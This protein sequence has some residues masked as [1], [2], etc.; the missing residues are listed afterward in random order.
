MSGRTFSRWLPLQ[1]GLRPDHTALDLDDG[2]VSYAELRRLVRGLVDVWAS[3]SVGPLDRG[4]RV[5]LYLD[6]RLEA[7]V[8]VLA[9]LDLGAVYVP[10]PVETPPAR[11]RRILGSCGTRHLVTTASLA[12]ALRAE[13]MPAAI[14]QVLVA[15]GEASCDDP[16]EVAWEDAVV[17]SAAAPGDV[18]K[19]SRVSEEDAAYMLFTSGSTGVPRGVV[20]SHRAG[21]AFVEWAVS[22]LGI[23]PGDRIAGVAGIHFDLSV[24][25][26][27]G[28]LATGATLV[29]LPPR[30][31]AR[32]R[33]A[34]RWILDREITVWYSTPSTLV[35]LLERGGFTEHEYPSLRRLLFA[36]EVLLPGH[37]RR[38]LDTL[39]GAELYNLYG[40][41]ETNVCTFKRVERPM[42]TDREVPIGK[43]CC[44][45]EVVALDPE[46]GTVGEGE[47]GELWVRGPTLMQGYWDAP[48]ETARALRPLDRPGPRGGRW[49]CTGDLVHRDSAGDYHFHGR[50]DQMVKVRGYRVEIGEV[51]RALHSVPWIAELAVVAAPSGGHGLELVAWV[52]PTDRDA[53]SVLELRSHLARQLPAWMIPRRFSCRGELPRTL[54]GKIDRSRLKRSARAL[55]RE[56]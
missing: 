40:P 8:A 3:S 10:V 29:P 24:F 51:E 23:E 30:L 26:L 41:T 44:G 36:G 14:R 22:A 37:L 15:G 25:D 21:S 56:G 12:R 27:F 46:A 5:G 49:Y 19:T 50:R 2:S 48:R 45:C 35:L 43:A 4:D 42:P 38:L 17:P 13:G 28:S 32:P 6:K 55:L 11:A 33:E 20:L 31:L 18:R 9:A 16:L 52:V 47:E 7:Y 54:S 34:V 39:P 53:F 1:A